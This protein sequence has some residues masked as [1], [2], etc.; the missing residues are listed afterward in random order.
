LGSLLRQQKLKRNL[1]WQVVA[2]LCLMTSDSESSGS[3]VRDV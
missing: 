3:S 2:E 1:D